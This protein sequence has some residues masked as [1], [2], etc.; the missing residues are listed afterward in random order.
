[1]NASRE[2]RNISAHTFKGG[3]AIIKM[4]VPEPIYR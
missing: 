3:D 2:G 1:M 4:R